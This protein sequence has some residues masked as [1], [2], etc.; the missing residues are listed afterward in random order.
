MKN[1]HI[2]TQAPKIVLVGHGMEAYTQFEL[3]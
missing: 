3:R 2:T 1:M